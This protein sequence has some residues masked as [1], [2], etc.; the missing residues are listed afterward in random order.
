EDEDVARQRI[1]ER[2]FH[3]MAARGVE[4]RV[5]RPRFRPVR[6]IGAGPLRLAAIDGTP[7]PAH[8]AETVAPHPLSRP[9]MAI[10]RAEP[11]HRLGDDGPALRRWL[12]PAAHSTN[13][14][15]SNAMPSVT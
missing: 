6:R 8:E 12:E 7:H 13:T 2:F 15:P 3:T 4:Q 5:A 10:R 9:L 14:P 11:R 1:A